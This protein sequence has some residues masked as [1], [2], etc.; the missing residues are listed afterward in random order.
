MSIK[1][2]IGQLTRSVCL[3]I[4]IV[5]L[6]ACGV[7]T[8]V[9]PTLRPSLTPAPIIKPTA[10]PTVTP[11]ATALPI[12]TP[13]A[14]AQVNATFAP[15][16]NPLTGEKVSDPNNLNRRPL[17]IIIANSN[18]VGVRPQSGTSMADWVFEHETEAPGITRW[19]AIF[20][21]QTPDRVGSDRS[22]RIID[23]E[24]PAIFKSL[25]ACSGASGGTWAYYIKPADF[26][27]EGRTFSQDL[28]DG[29]PM[30]FR[31][32]NAV[33]PHNLFVHPAEIWKAAEKRNVNTKP[34]LSGLSF[35]SQLAA[36]SSPASSI[37]LKFHSSSVDWKYDP[38]AKTCSSLGGCYLRWN[39][40]APH[41]DALNGQQI[42]VANMIV[43]YVNYTQDVRYL[44]EEY[45]AL[46]LFGWQIQLWGDPGGDVKIFRDG[47]EFDGKWFRPARGDM[48]SF[49]DAKG[50]VLSLKPGN[51][52]V[53]LVPVDGKV[54]VTP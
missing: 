46:K 31:T 42:G 52:W 39:D 33:P 3:L 6:A 29:V 5:L 19:G 38:N 21:G 13:T 30:F 7:D 25:L 4:P 47:Q 23:D 36:S 32:D 15:D 14:S 26:T 22:C 27:L 48:L 2:F 10:R 34:D 20:Y 40:G 35:S 12:A 50:Q 1:S 24:L 54:N 18:E 16:I 11:E 17:E 41:T 28:G 53:E 44:E 45:G 51:T 37:G 49:K 43:I 9:S 8:P